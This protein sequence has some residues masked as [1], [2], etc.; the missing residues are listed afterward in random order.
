MSQPDGKQSSNTDRSRESKGYVFKH[1]RGPLIQGLSRGPALE[2][3][4]RLAAQKE[5][6]GHQS[7]EGVKRRKVQ[8]AQV[9][10]ANPGV[11]MRDLKDR[12]TLRISKR[13]TR[14]TLQDEDD[15]VLESGDFCRSAKM[16]A[17]AL[18]DEMA[19]GPK[20]GRGGVGNVHLLD[21][22]EQKHKAL[23]EDNEW[24]ANGLYA[25]LPRRPDNL[26]DDTLAA[27]ASLQPN[28][29]LLK[30]KGGKKAQAPQKATMT[31]LQKA[32][33]AVLKRKAAE[34]A[35]EPTSG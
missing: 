13:M 6:E 4:A 18:L 3:E 16:S 29:R 33:A 9:D 8:V 15:Q 31:A 12:A 23:D 30:E 11:R 17:E 20:Q 5:A 21:E 2:L 19:N 1:R 22:H 27:L 24:L 10:R 25:K 7:I 26:G 35:K 32:K 34:A 28:K 14:G